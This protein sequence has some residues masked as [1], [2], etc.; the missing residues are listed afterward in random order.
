MSSDCL[1][2]SLTPL[3][4]VKEVRPPGTPT[5]SSE[6]LTTGQAIVKAP[7]KPPPV[8]VDLNATLDPVESRQYKFMDEKPPYSYATLIIFAINSSFQKKLTLSQ[9]YEWIIS[10]FAYYKDTHTGWK[11]RT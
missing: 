8:P 7:R 2:S 6:R 1:N 3:D 9:I 10:N 4:W 5:E 11:V